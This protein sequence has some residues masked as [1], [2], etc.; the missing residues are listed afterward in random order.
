MRH[1][2][3]AW[4]CGASIVGAVALVSC[5]TAQTPGLGAAA[6]PPAGSLRPRFE[7]L[8]LTPKD[9][10]PRGC[11][12][13]FA[14]C[15]VLEFEGAPSTGGGPPVRLSEE[16]LNWASHQTNGRRSDGSFFA[17]A[18]RGLATFGVCRE[19]LLPYGR[20]FL[21]DLEPSAAAH[22][23]AEGRRGLQAVWIKPWDVT[24]GMTAEMLAAIRRELAG[25]HPVAIGMRWPQD[26]RYSPAGWLEV[27]PPEQV[28]DG[29]SV[30]LV[31]WQDDGEVPGGGSFTFRNSFG[32]GWREG[33]YGRLP[34]A[35]VADYGNDALALRLGGGELMP[36][37]RG[38]RSPIEFE[39]L[40]MEDA[41]GCS[42]AVQSMRS[43]G[44]ARWSGGAH[45]FAQAEPGAALTVAFQPAVP[46][47]YRLALFA[48][49]APDYGILRLSLDH[50][51]LAGDT[52]LYAAEV[53]PTGRLALG[54]VEL[55]PGVHRL[56]VEVVGRNPASTGSCLGLDCLELVPVE[57][58]GPDSLDCR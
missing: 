49:R 48:T 31:G 51:P 8:G 23:D 19:E 44:A 38:A 27:P 9:Q 56:R 15:G 36:C 37:N 43:W 17:D 55:A 3:L 34:Y 54:T 35:Y 52:D 26:E 50:Q 41:Q 46:G 32:P 12:S 21:P 42:P 25:G 58:V 45:W 7:R 29:H 39:A 6:V 4:V 22:A 28:F 2:G 10:A 1:I 53:E 30:V 14:L 33:G 24:T 40:T 57:R 18:L 16:Y 5:G 47:R 13:L 11:C 20:E